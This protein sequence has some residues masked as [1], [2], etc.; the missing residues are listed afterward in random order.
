MYKKLSVFTLKITLLL[1]VWSTS[2]AESVLRVDCYDSNEGAIIYINGKNEGLCPVALF[3]SAG[4]IKLK[5]RKKVDEDYSRFFEQEF[6]LGA[7]TAKKVEVILSGAQLTVGGAKRQKQKKLR[8][9]K[10]QNQ[11]IEKVAMTA[12]TKARAGDI[13]AMKAISGYYKQ[14]YG[15]K[16]NTQ[17]ADYWSAKADTMSTLKK[18]EAGDLNAMREIAYI[19]K[20]GNGLTKD[21]NKASMWEEK[22]AHRISLAANAGYVD[23]DTIKAMRQLS[24]FYKLGQGVEQSDVSA[25]KWEEK[26]DRATIMLAD[27]NGKEQQ[28]AMT[29]TEIEEIS[30]FYLTGGLIENWDKIVDEGP[31]VATTA[32][33]TFTVLAPVGDL[34]TGPIRTTNQIRLNSQLSARASSWNNPNSMIAKA[35]QQKH[36]TTESLTLW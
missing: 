12:L 18:A 36:K 16:R 7:D 32:G 11:Q 8:E 23:D 26:A 28:D 5:A 22:I 19:Y 21:T 30:Y 4:K 9:E 25:R 27:K 20:T 17:K 29:R 31:T 6:Y 1:I 24:N 2:S 35:S 15:V 10:R 33:P 34:L 13:D 14:G 3:R